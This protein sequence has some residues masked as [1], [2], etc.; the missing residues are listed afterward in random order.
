MI[1]K[2]LRREHRQNILWHKSYQC[3]LQSVSLSNRNKG[4]NKQMGPNQTHKL[5]HSKGNYKQMK[6]Q[7]MDGE[8]II[9]GEMTDK[10]L[11]SKMHRKLTLLNN[12]EANNTTEKWMEDLNRH[13]FKEEMQMANRYMKRRPATLIIREMQIKVTRSYHLTPVRMPII[14]KNANN[15]CS[16]KNME[17]R[18]P[19]YTICGNVNW[20]SHCGKQYGSFSKK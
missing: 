20:C 17:K 16:V 14:K 11:I 18:K 19:L 9:A 1:L 15:K 2:T 8:E 13:F 7:P 6:R 4:K 3:L 10:G 5:L 12:K